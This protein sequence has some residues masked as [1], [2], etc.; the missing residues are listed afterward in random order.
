[1][2]KCLPL[3]ETYEKELTE[4]FVRKKYIYIWVIILLNDRKE[5][6]RKKVKSEANMIK[7]VSVEY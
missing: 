1:M 2:A 6:E 5:R 3:G 4:Q 7:L